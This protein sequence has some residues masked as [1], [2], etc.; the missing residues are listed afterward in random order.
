[1]ARCASCAF[2]ETTLDECTTSDGV[3][4]DASAI[5]ANGRR[6]FFGAGLE[7]WAKLDAAGICKARAVGQ[8]E[9]ETAD[10]KAAKEEAALGDA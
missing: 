6:K 9:E 3:T 4:D 10:V 1:M 2:S 7:S 8:G 5:G